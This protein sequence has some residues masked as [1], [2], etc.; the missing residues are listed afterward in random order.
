[1]TVDGSTPTPTHGTLVGHVGVAALPGGTTVL[2]AIAFDPSGVLANS[3]IVSASYTVNNVSDPATVT[4][5]PVIQPSSGSYNVKKNP[6]T[7]QFFYNMCSATPSAEFRATLDGTDPDFNTTHGTLFTGPGVD[8][9]YLNF[10]SGQTRNY[11]L[12][13][14]AKASGKTQSNVVT[15]NISLTD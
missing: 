14:R 7:G 4:A 6:Q 13:A 12:K 8:G 1:M 10:Y 9:S 11:T 5:D 15:A 3:A 2:K